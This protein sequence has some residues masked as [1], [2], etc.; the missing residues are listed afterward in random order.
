VRARTQGITSN[1]VRTADKLPSED[2]LFRANTRELH[3]AVA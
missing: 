2:D 1:H 3:D